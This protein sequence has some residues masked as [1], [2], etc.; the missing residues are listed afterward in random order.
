MVLTPLRIPAHAMHFNVSVGSAPPPTSP[1]RFPRVP[2]WLRINGGPHA[3]RGDDLR[4]QDSLE[5]AAALPAGDPALLRRGLRGPGLGAGRAPGE[6]T[7]GR[8]QLLDGSTRA[9]ILQGGGVRA[10]CACVLNWT[11]GWTSARRSWSGAR[12]CLLP[13]PRQRNVTRVRAWPWWG[14]GMWAFGARSRCQLQQ[15]T[16]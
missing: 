2:P 8:K 13:T 3:A 16:P 9:N 14:K 15:H 10:T 12:G 7:V 4:R 1:A 5:A 6:G 11:P